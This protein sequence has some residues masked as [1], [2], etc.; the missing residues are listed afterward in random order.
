MHLLAIA[1]HMPVCRY[2]ALRREAS[3]T[4]AGNDM[5]RLRIVWTTCK[6]S[7]ITYNFPGLVPSTARKLYITVR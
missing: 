4:E 7:S 5:V 1:V 3:P 6:F 2:D